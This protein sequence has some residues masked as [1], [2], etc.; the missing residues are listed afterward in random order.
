M[1]ASDRAVGAV[2]EGRYRLEARLS[3]WGAGECWRA[4]DTQRPRASVTVKILPPPAGRR[5]ERMASLKLLGDRLTKLQHPSILPIIE[6]NTAGAQPLVVYDAWESVGLGEWLASARAAGEPT[7]LRTVFGVA[8]R[9]L[10]AVGAGHRQRSP[11]AL[12]HGALHHE[13][14]RVRIEMGRDPEV[15]VI[16]FGLSA[17]KDA[18]ALVDSSPSE[19][20]A[21][22]HARE[23]S[24]RNA[25]TDVFAAAVLVLRLLVPEAARPRGHRSWAHF[26]SQKESEVHAAITALRADVDPTIW[27]ALAQALAR[28]PEARPADAERLREMLRAASWGASASVSLAVEEPLEPLVPMALPSLQALAP[29]VPA[30]S[31][32]T[33]PPVVAAPP[34]PVVHAPPVA[35]PAGPPPVPKGMQLGVGSVLGA[36]RPDAPPRPR[37]STAGLDDRSFG[38]APPASRPPTKVSLDDAAATTLDVG[39]SPLADVDAPTGMVTLPPGPPSAKVSLADADRTVQSPFESPDATRV[40]PLPAPAPSQGSTRPTHGDW[41]EPSWG[42]QPPMVGAPFPAPISLAAATQPIALE[43][44]PPPV[45]AALAAYAA[46]THASAWD[47]TSNLQPVGFQ[48]YPPPAAPPAY[49]APPTYAAPR[50]PTDPFAMVAAAGRVDPRAWDASTTPPVPSPG[51]PRKTPVALLVGLALFVAVAAFLLGLAAST[52]SPEPTPAPVVR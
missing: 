20:G 23:P 7:P 8:D 11:G 12:I 32:A 34:P 37:R 1:S 52:R 36:H 27:A 3:N 10:A 17:E 16:D 49:A 39:F 19:Y 47:S 25:A 24:L 30:L 28:R 35:A 33:P 15:R 46:P 43:A 5:T 41:S 31:L 4:V 2:L 13:A 26:V 22:E 14:A 44:A 18:A 48:P 51:A 6:V 29:P 40:G 42:S 9:L 21:P 50:A 38:G 45:V